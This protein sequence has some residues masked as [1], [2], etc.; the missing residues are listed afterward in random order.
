MVNFKDPVVISRDAFAAA[1]LYHTVDGLYIW[2]FIINLDYEWSV[3]RGHRP[4]RWTIWL[5]SFTRVATLAAMITDMIGIDTS[6]PI[7]C[8]FWLT[9]T[10]AT[11]Y[12]AVATASLLIA[13]RVI[14]I[15]NRNKIVYAIAMSAWMANVACIIHAVVRLRSIWSP[16]SRTCVVSN[17]TA[18]QVNLMVTL[19]TDILMLLVMLVGLLR[20]RF[21]EGGVSGLTRFL[22]IQGL[23][24]LLLATIG[25]LPAAIFVLLNLN[26]PFNVMFG[27]STVTTVSIA[28][29]RMYRTL[30][31]YYNN[32][33]IT[34]SSP[35][36]GRLPASQTNQIRV[37][38][39]PIRFNSMD[40]SGFTDSG[41][42]RTSQTLASRSGTYIITDG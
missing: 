42:R 17:S 28:G 34:F 29:T 30:T 19:A 15:W 8:Q 7:H 26:D 38:T 1:K 11:A 12:A 32:C 40:A 4:Y 23:I 41:Q 33:D 9:F 6:R 18:N 20:W 31:D 16:T 24:W 36:R 3:I 25:H 10:V 14:A 5:Y 21:R 22:W 35:I 37:V 27:A 2:E 39:A 13:L